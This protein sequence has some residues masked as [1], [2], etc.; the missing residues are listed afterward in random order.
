MF[1]DKSYSLPTSGSGAYMKLEEGKNKF[2]M[3]SDIVT[4]Y[5]YWTNDNKPVRQKEDWKG[6]LPS[7]AKPDY[8]GGPQKSKHFWA[9]VVWNYATEQVE[10]LSITQ[11][12]VQKQMLAWYDNDEWG[13]PKGYDITI[14]KSGQGRDTEYV[15]QPSPAKPLNP[16][17]KKAY[18]SMT[19]DL[20]QLYEGGNP[21]IDTADD[22]VDDADL[23][24]L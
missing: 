9:F 2:R 13:D 6:G 4:G 10:I 14:T 5:E 12:T 24:N 7:D 18:Q 22:Y 20:D 23:E 15:V 19:I 17:I 1:Q 11:K 16:E 3:L 21:F 8:N